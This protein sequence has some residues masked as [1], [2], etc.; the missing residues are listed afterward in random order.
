MDELIF[1]GEFPSEERMTEVGV[2][3][4]GSVDHRVFRQ[5]R[6]RHG[7]PM[8]IGLKPALARKAMEAEMARMIKERTKS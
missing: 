3:V 8:G 4:F 7:L 6:M 2:K 1:A 5:E